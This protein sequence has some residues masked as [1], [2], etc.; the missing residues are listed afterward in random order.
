MT[1]E[2]RQTAYGDFPSSDPSKPLDLIRIA[3]EQ[4]PPLMTAPRSNGDDT[5]TTSEGD[6]LSTAEVMRGLSTERALDGKALRARL[7]HADR[8]VV[9]QTARRVSDSLWA[10]L[11]AV[12]DLLMQ[13]DDK[14]STQGFGTLAQEERHALLITR[15]RVLDSFRDLKVFA[16]DLCGLVPTEAL[17]GKPDSDLPAGWAT[18]LSQRTERNA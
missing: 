3:Y 14:P 13:D 12:D 9:T 11:D 2:D 6:V 16:P 18:T 5:W 10:A 17:T 8:R 4:E 7:S 15:Q 1:H